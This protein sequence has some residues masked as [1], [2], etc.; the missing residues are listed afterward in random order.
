MS[1]E[2]VE[3]VEVVL[4]DEVVSTSNV[5]VAREVIAG[6]WGRG[7]RRKDRLKDAGYDPVEVQKEVD[8]IFNRS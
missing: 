6:R 2:N 4:E 7:N 1:D 5:E 8:K 3:V